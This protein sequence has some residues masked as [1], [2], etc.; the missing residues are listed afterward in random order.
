MSC[1]NQ[2][3]PTDKF[4]IAKTVL[5]DSKSFSYCSRCSR[6]HPSYPLHQTQK[7]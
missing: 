3:A 4:S 2:F 1:P 7:T 5:V 6:F